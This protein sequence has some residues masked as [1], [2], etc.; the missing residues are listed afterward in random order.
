MKFPATIST[1]QPVRSND[2]GLHR[3]FFGHIFDG[4]NFCAMEI[5]NLFYRIGI[6]RV[7]MKCKL[8]SMVLLIALMQ[9]CNTID[10]TL[11]SYNAKKIDQ[12]NGRPV[13]TAS[14]DITANH[15]ELQPSFTKTAFTKICGGPF[16]IRKQTISEPFEKEVTRTR[17]TGVIPGT[18]AVNTQTT[19]RKIPHVR[20]DYEIA[21]GSNS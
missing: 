14:I 18:S 6:W 1:V 9:G 7:R 15:A 20:Y 3:L 17:V 16:T 2:R 10:N 13:Y 8:I 19:K 5:V 21:C 4:A 12:N 11:R